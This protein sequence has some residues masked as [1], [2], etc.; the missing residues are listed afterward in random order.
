MIEESQDLTFAFKDA[1]SVY[2]TYYCLS[3]AID[4]IRDRAW[5]EHIILK[6]GNTSVQCTNCGQIISEQK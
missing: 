4:A 3:C 6:R 1:A 2:D 5:L